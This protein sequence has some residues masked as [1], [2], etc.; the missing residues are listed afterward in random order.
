MEVKEE[1]MTLNEISDPSRPLAETLTVKY[2][3]TRA[4]KNS[5]LIACLFQRLV[6]AS[7]IYFFISASH[8]SLPLRRRSLQCRFPEVSFK[9]ISQGIHSSL[10]SL[11]SPDGSHIWEGTC[12]TRNYVQMGR[13]K[14][15]L[16]IVRFKYIHPS[17]KS[18]WGQVLTEE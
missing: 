11:N 5:F 2:L 17:M 14:G 18:T 9:G 12:L 3:S 13:Q 1:G 15:D 16:Q 6:P 8:I 4:C 10:P 7:L